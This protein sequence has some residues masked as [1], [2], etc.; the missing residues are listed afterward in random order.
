MRLLHVINAPIFGGAETAVIELLTELQKDRYQC[1]AELCTVFHGQDLSPGI[2]R[3]GITWHRLDE[4]KTLTAAPTAPLPG[5]TVTR[6]PTAIRRLVRLIKTNEYDVVHGHLF[7]TFYY[8]ALASYL[9]GGP[10][11][12][13]SEH[14]V[15]N[16][17]R[18]SK[19]YRPLERWAYGRFDKLVAVSRPVADNLIGWMPRFRNRIELI[20]NGLQIPPDYGPGPEKYSG[21]MLFVG[22]L[23]RY[24][25]LDVL[26][27]AMAGLKSSGRPLRQLIIAGHGPDARAIRQQ[28]RDSGLGD[29]IE[30]LGPLGREEVFD[31]I[32]RA[33]ALVLPSRWEGLPMAVLEALALKTPVVATDVGGVGDLVVDGG[34]GRLVPAENPEALAE[35]IDW[36]TRVPE[37][38]PQ[39]GVNGRRLV[40]KDFSIES[41]ARRH[42][43]LYPEP[44]G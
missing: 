38:L 1:R 3:A 14:S 18:S 40:E 20:E 7:P 2:E 9:A 28:A 24:K 29:R 16:R 21:P 25:G 23:W 31:L 12:V 33:A 32:R 17:R 37:A 10:Y 30:F 27:E 35:A 11:Y 34:T 36:V 22:G 43:K 4:P 39:M 42:L 44:T 13:Y 26:F 19:L 41:A 6:T 15:H 8:L 5:R